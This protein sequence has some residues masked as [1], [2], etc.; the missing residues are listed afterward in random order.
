MSGETVPSAGLISQTTTAI[1]TPVIGSIL[2]VAWI[3]VLYRL[4]VIRDRRPTMTAAL[5]YAIF[6]LTYASLRIAEIHW[7]IVDNTPLRLGDVRVIGAMLQVC[8]ATALLLLALRWRSRTGFLPRRVW[9]CAAVIVTVLSVLLVI[10][11]IPASAAEIA[12]EE[13]RGS[14]C[15]GAYL[16]LHSFMYLPA[17]VTIAVTLA[18]MARVGSLRRRILAGL[19][20]LA[21]VLS[22]INLTS[23]MAGGWLVSAGVEGPWN[24][25]R[26]SARND[27]ALY[28]TL[29]PWMIAGIPG[30]VIHLRR[31]L[32]L[33]RRERSR[34]NALEPLW[35]SLTDTAPEYRLAI[36]NGGVGALPSTTEREH[37]V[38]TEIEDII[39]AVSRFLP[40]NREWPVSAAGRA[41]VLDEACALYQAADSTS[42]VRNGFGVRPEWATDDDAVDEVAR[43]WV[44]R[45]KPPPLNA[46]REV[47]SLRRGRRGASV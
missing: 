31:V 20:S 38:R 32:H 2:L 26:T 44:G 19:L 40:A 27:V 18:Q 46:S 36:P 5:W 4:C 8:A 45:P 25:P 41:A 1:P 23:V 9:V 37:R 33:N 14:W 24:T 22:A 3:V 47:P 16:T 42:A 43:A 28:P 17:E 30:V 21:I 15:V 11:H 35:K 10:V 34:R 7:W 13:M 12:V 6:I 29:I 39:F